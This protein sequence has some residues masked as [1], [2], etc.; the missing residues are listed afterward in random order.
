[1]ELRTMIQFAVELQ[2]LLWLY[3]PIEVVQ[4]KGFEPALLE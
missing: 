1:M 2:R 3:G 4:V